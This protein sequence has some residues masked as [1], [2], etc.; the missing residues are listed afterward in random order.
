MY[1]FY[2]FTLEKIILISDLP[3]E[4]IRNK[5]GYRYEIL[6]SVKDKESIEIV[7]ERMK[8]N[9]LQ[10]TFS[11]IFKK[12]KVV[13]SQE[14]RNKISESKK[15]K[16]RDE[17]TRAKISASCKGRSNFQGKSHTPETKARMAAKKL[18]NDHAK[19]LHWAHDPRGDAE[20]RVKEIK[21][22]P[23]GFSKGRDYYSTEPGLYHFK[24][25]SI[26]RHRG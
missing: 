4:K 12:P 24:Q 9:Y 15:G 3:V 18:G 17:E 21:D 23:S 6:T 10:Y 20:V 25:F 14:V 13:L 1:F 22:I 8:R 16:P 5:Y 2:C 11:Q 26:S 19:A 7:I